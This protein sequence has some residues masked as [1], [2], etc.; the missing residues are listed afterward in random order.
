MVISFRTYNDSETYGADY[1][2]IRS[3]LVDLDS[4]SYQF[5]R[6]DWMISHSLLDKAGLSKIGIWED[7]GSI[8]GFAAYDTMIDGKCFFPMKPGYGFLRSEMIEYAEK[9]LAHNGCI[10][11][12]I[13]D[14]DTAFQGAARKMG[15]I[16]T[17]HK[18]SD[19]NLDVDNMHY[20][21]PD[22]FSVTSLKD[23]YDLYQYGR[24]LWKGFDHEADGEG[25]YAPA[26][27]S[28]EVFRGEFERPN[29]NLD[30]KIAV[31]APDGNFASYCG[32]W[33]DPLSQ[34]VLVEPAATDPAYRKMGLGRA[35]VLEAI[36]R[37]GQLGATRAYVGSSHQFY[38]S[39]GFR[40]TTT[41]T[42]WVKK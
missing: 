15:Y 31:T 2:Q 22:G 9:N 25:E 3:F 33:H 37:C 17:Q 29:I 12:L 24:I 7:N 41:S 1:H 35:A 13:R 27:E 38:Y 4:P 6:W 34:S 32:M 11:L 36:R 39:L 14:G 10:R 18:A 21:L 30:I 5:G 23:K 26:A 40:P 8:I 42:F 28:L 20:P 19:S 16:A